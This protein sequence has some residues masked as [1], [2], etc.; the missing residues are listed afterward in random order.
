[1]TID[2]AGIAPA[3]AAAPKES[4][5]RAQPVAGASGNQNASGLIDKVD[6]TALPTPAAP[7][8]K[9]QMNVDPQTSQLVIQVV[10]GNTTEIIRKIPAE[11]V[12]EFAHTLDSP[13]GNLIQSEA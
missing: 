13:T 12:V 6:N 9:V 1:M 7:Q 5:A 8:S 11:E 4:A 3:S 10:A 2:I